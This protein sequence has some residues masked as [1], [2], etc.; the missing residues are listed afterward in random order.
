VNKG[1]LVCCVRSEH[2]RF[3]GLLE[4]LS[5]ARVTKLRVDVD[6]VSFVVGPHAVRR[7]SVCC[8]RNAELY[9]MIVVTVEGLLQMPYNRICRDLERF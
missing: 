3:R 5:V 2:T 9:R 4:T 8:T 7:C 1:P 6:T